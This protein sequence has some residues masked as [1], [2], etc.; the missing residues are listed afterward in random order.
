MTPDR[1]SCKRTVRLCYLMKLEHQV[2]HYFFLK[3]H[4]FLPQFVYDYYGKEKIRSGFFDLSQDGFELQSVAQRVSPLVEK[5]V[6]HFMFENIL[7][8]LPAFFLQIMKG[9]SNES[10]LRI[11]YSQKSPKACTQPDSAVCQ[12]IFKMSL[13]YLIERL[14]NESGIINSL[15]YF[16]SISLRVK[17]ALTAREE[18]GRVNISV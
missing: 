10:S 4:R 7:K 11:S 13:V 14:P 17:V 1:K 16:F 2:Q 5:A 12:S 15:F 9:Y 3:V 18:R 6:K 8:I